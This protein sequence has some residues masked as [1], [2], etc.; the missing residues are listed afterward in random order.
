MFDSGAMQQADNPLTASAA[1]A[2]S[3]RRQPLTASG[4]RCNQVAHFIILAVN[5]SRTLDDP[6]D[7]IDE[8]RLTAWGVLI[9]NV[10]QARA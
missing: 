2:A 10:C 9:F 6:T 7:I 8:D 3:Q 5:G 1:S 4:M